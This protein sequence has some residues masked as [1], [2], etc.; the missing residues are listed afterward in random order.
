[1]TYILIDANN[2][3]YR[4]K[5]VTHGD[6]DIKGGM[7]LHIIFNALSK[8]WRMFNGSHVVVALEGG[9]RTNS[10]R[11]KQYNAYKAHRAVQSIQR[12]EREKDDD[13]L[14]FEYINEFIKFIHE[15]TN[16]SVIQAE[17]CEA[18]D[19]I[20]R[21]IHLH[22]KD[23][24]VI[25]SSDTDF[26]QLLS[27]NVQIYNGITNETINLKGFF[28]DKGNPTLNTRTKKPKDPLD[29]KWELFKKCMLGDPGDGIF[30]AAPPRIRETKI[31]EA[32]NDHA[33]KG[34]AWNNL[35]LSTWVDCDG[36]ERRVLDRYLENKTLIDLTA[37]P[38][39]IKLLL[40]KT[41]LNALTVTKKTNI[42]I[43]LMRFCHT[44]GLTRIEQNADRYTAFLN[45]SYND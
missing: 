32:F 23:N 9:R 30:R 33:D 37:Q 25:L 1:M 35:M 15:H 24:H 42:G 19:C 21:W 2:L 29:P 20:A 16:C 8:T 10:W 5:H 38:D 26:Y 41:I 3:F 18:D 12:T 43:W 45:A 14:Y 6:A 13:A 44:Y 31:R 40:D 4:C 28:D 22:P 27:D 39:D 36:N 11:Y 34:F 7:A 17:S